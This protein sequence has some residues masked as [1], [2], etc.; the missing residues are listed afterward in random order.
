MSNHSICRWGRC[1]LVRHVDQ[2]LRVRVAEVALVRQAEVDLVLVEGVLDLVGEDT[3]GETR[4]DLLDPSVVCRM[5][6]VI[7]DEDVVPEERELRRVA[8]SKD[9]CIWTSIGVDRGA[10]CISCS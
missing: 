10:P 4:D 8:E 6:D 5:K 3:R 1:L 7:V 2:P 9:G